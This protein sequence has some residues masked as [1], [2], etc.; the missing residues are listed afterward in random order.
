MFC[1][2]CGKEL[3][4]RAKFCYFCGTK[5]ETEKDAEAGKIKTEEKGIQ[6]TETD[7]QLEE[8][9]QKGK[10]ELLYQHWEQANH[11]FEQ[12]VKLDFEYAEAYWG[13]VLSVN[14]CRNQE[15]FIAKYTKEEG[16]IQREDLEAVD[17]QKNVEEAVKKYEVRGFLYEEKIRQIFLYEKDLHYSSEVLFR[18]KQYERVKE[19]FEEDQYL[20]KVFQCAEGEFYRNVNQV[21]QRIFSVWEERLSRA[22][23]QEKEQLKVIMEDYDAFLA[24]AK[25]KTEQEYQCA[26]EQ[27]LSSYTEACRYMKEGQYAI[28][29]ARFEKLGDFKNSRSFLLECQ[30]YEQRKNPM[31]RVG[32]GFIAANDSDTIIGSQ[33][34]NYWGNDYQPRKKSHSGI[35][36]GL[37]IAAVIIVIIFGIGFYQLEKEGRP[38]VNFV[39]EGHPN[40]YP[41]ITY[42]EAFHSFFSNPQWYYFEAETGEDVVEFTGNCLYYEKEVEVMV[43]FVL[44]Y[45][46]N[47]FEIYA[48]ELNDIPQSRLEIW[49]LVDRV[50]EDYQDSWN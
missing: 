41:G 21:R 48:F 24:Q 36:K 32:N 9:I 46:N 6:K 40:S 7:L 29:I 25:E 17:H 1:I 28:A 2:N 20:K 31:S 5:T 16:E 30:Q 11:Y 35:W 14:Q 50:F 39:K 49:A 33:N 22:K 23:K 3:S 27:Q 19:V 38:Y 26:V 45:K 18:E 44:D 43:Q 10:Q 8:W 15:E 12:V 34:R 47:T 13:L 4:D 37:G 42:E